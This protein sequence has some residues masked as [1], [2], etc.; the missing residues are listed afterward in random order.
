MYDDLLFPSNVP[1][2]MHECIILV[3]IIPPPPPSPHLSCLYQ[4]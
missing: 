1:V 2:M 3:V 4:S